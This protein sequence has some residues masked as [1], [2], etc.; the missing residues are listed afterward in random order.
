MQ[1]ILDHNMSPLAS[2]LNAV[3]QQLNG[4]LTPLMQIIGAYEENSTRERFQTKQG[5]DDIDWGTLMSSTIAAKKNRGGILVDYGD[6]MR[7]ITYHAST[8]SVAIGTPEEYGKY[9]QEGTQYM[10]AR[11]FLGLSD[12]DETNLLE[13]TNEYLAGVV[14]G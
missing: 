13:L 5:P 8:S 1:L 7:S 14:Y 11:K 6:L 2:H 4:N 3:Y 10:T 9:H 12:D